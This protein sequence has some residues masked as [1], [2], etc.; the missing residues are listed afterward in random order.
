MIECNDRYMRSVSL[1]TKTSQ[2]CLCMCRFKEEK[3]LLPKMRR[4]CLCCI[5]FQWQLNVLSKVLCDTRHKFPPLLP[6]AILTNYTCT[7]NRHAVFLPTRIQKESTDLTPNLG[8]NTAI[9]RSSQEHHEFILCSSKQN[10]YRFH[11]Q[12]LTLWLTQHLMKAV[13]FISLSSFGKRTF[14]KTAT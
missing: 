9:Y 3:M 5:T 14:L 11:G 12:T 10:F 4:F 2:G 7:G 6:R 8:L 13:V 1:K